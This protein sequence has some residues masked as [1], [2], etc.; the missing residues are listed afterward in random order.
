[1]YITNF[2]NEYDF[3]KWLCKSLPPNIFYCHV[4]PI[5][6]PGHPDLHL[7]TNFKIILAEL[8]AVKN[9]NIKIRSVF[10]KCQIPWYIRYRQKGGDVLYLIIW[11]KEERLFQTTKINNSIY[12]IDMN[13]NLSQFVWENTMSIVSWVKEKLK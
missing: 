9:L 5:G 8:K 2:Q 6:D 1:M 7:W 10:E 11:N 4:E 12:D 13:G 3:Q